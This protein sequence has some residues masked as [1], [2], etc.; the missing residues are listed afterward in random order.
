MYDQ[1][2]VIEQDYWT[3]NML[4]KTNQPE[5]EKEFFNANKEKLIKYQQI[6]HVKSVETEG[7]N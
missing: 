2:S 3:W 6:E 1:A 5:A 7:I 4:R